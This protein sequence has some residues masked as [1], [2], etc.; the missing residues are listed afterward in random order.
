MQITV[1]ELQEALAE[2]SEENQ[3]TSLWWLLSHYWIGDSS[4]CEEVPADQDQLHDSPGANEALDIYLATKPEKGRDELGEVGGVQAA[5]GL[6]RAGPP[7]GGGSAAAVYTKED[8]GR[9]LLRTQSGTSKHPRVSSRDS[10]AVEIGFSQGLSGTAQ[11]PGASQQASTSQHPGAL[12][13]ASTSQHPGASRHASTSKR[14]SMAR[15][16][17][18]VRVARQLGKRTASK[19]QAFPDLRQA[20]T[21][22]K[23]FSTKGDVSVDETGHESP[24]TTP[25]T[26]DKPS[27]RQVAFASPSAVLTD[28][29]YYLDFESTVPDNVNYGMD[30]I[31]VHMDKTQLQRPPRSH[32][33]GNGPAR[34]KALSRA[35]IALSSR[36]SQSPRRG[37]S[38]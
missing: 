8:G 1:S 29:A 2:E 16:L 26:K 6:V 36:P 7:P 32:R 17:A 5:S 34:W 24:R 10:T 9:V 18:A 35:A 3:T 11:H 15:L 23:Q 20:S 28:S 22:P 31:D 13:Q 27:T 19:R 21:E 38:T 30:F 25:R 37:R 12:Q 4:S 33:L 14:P